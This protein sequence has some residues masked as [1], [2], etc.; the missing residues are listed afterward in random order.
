MRRLVYLGGDH[1]SERRGSK[2]RPEPGHDRGRHLCADFSRRHG[3]ASR[4]LYD[5]KLGGKCV[6]W[7]WR[8]GWPDAR[9]RLRQ[10]KRHKGYWCVRVQTASRPR[11]YRDARE[12]PPTGS[13]ATFAGITPG[14]LSVAENRLRTALARQITVT[15][16]PAPFSI[17]R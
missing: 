14:V 4:Q 13:T 9:A 5:R 15:I 11:F 8:R 2:N 6:T 12:R 17:P 3:L 10:T 16:P 1:G 7:C